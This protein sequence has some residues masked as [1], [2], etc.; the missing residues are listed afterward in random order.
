MWVALSYE[1]DA[2]ATQ[3]E[4]QP[5]AEDRRQADRKIAEAK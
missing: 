3:E 4:P 5:D 1:P 2:A